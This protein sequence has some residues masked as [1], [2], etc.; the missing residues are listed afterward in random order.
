MRYR[1][2]RF[3]PR[4]ALQTPPDR[5]GVAPHV[6]RA[7]ADAAMMEEIGHA[8]PLAL[9]D[10]IIFLLTAATE[11]EHS[12]LVQYLYAA[13]SLETD[14]ARFVGPDL[15]QAVRLTGKAAGWQEKIAKTAQEEMGHLMTLQNVL[16]LLGGPLNFEREV[17]PFRSQFYPFHFILEP[18][19]KTS[20]AKYIAAEMPEHPDPQVMSEYQRRTILQ[21]AELGTNGLPINRVGALYQTLIELVRMLPEEDFVLDDANHDE[22]RLKLSYEADADS[23]GASGDL[24]PFNGVKLILATKS[25]VVD[26]LT[27]IARQ[28]EGTMATA[29]QPESHFERFL[30]IYLD[31][32]F[33]DERD[34]PVS[35]FAARPVP[36]NP[37]TSEASDPDPQQERILVPGRITNSTTLLW[38]QLFNVRYRMLLAD[39]VHYLRLSSLDCVDARSKLNE[40]AFV[41]MLIGIKPL[42][43]R[44][45]TLRQHA[46]DSRGDFAVAGAPFE[47]PYTLAMPLSE[48]DRWRLHRDLLV[49]SD[50]LIDAI[51]NTPSGSDPD[52]P[53]LKPIED[54]DDGRRSFIAEQI[55]QA[56]PTLVAIAGG[57]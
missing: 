15:T 12:L 20:L 8:A 42:A 2:L 4:P 18:L 56:V 57:S 25:S 55:T 47:L 14:P 30:S 23:W 41:E 9:R 46:D 36:T 32:D 33:P 5:V 39:L 1:D 29:A 35:W 13:Y 6:E 26:A 27:V 54:F 51:R 28:G 7:I 52:D 43:L 38:A 48:A 49:A 19:T 37:N 16:R 44:L 10:Q 17:F 34:E 3:R 53:V 40:Y 22:S 50:H 24:N 11:V 21:R 31:S 45:T